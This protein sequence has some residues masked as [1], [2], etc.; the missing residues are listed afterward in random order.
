M[1]LQ[2]GESP[3]PSLSPAPRPWG[4]ESILALTGLSRKQDWEPT[5]PG[6]IQVPPWGVNQEA[7]P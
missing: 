6:Q 1:T 2:W 5:P 4:C 3:F 7:G